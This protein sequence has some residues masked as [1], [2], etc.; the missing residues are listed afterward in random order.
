LAKRADLSAHL[1]IAI[2]EYQGFGIELIEVS[3]SDANPLAWRD[4]GAQH[5]RQG[6]VHFA[7]EVADL[8]ATANTLRERGA[9][10]ACELTTLKELGI[11]YFHIFDRDGNLL[12]FG[13]RL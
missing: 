1:R 10:F 12:E 2:V 13:Q 3:G 6:V 9:R 4:P 8:E 5:L 7:F 11:R